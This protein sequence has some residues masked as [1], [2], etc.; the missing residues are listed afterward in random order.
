MKYRIKNIRLL[1][2]E[3]DSCDI[4]QDGIIDVRDDRITYA[5]VANLAP[6]EKDFD[7]VIDGKKNLIMPG[8]KNAHTHSGMTFLRSYAD[9]MALQSWLND[10]VFPAEAKLTAEDIYELTKL[11]ILEYISSGVTAA[12][13]MYLTPESIAEAFE[14]MGMRCVQVSALNNFSQSIELMENMYNELNQP[15]SLN[16]YCMGF[17]AQYTCDDSLLRKVAAL[18]KKY[19]APVFAHISET[20]AEVDSCIEATGMTPVKYLDSLGMFENGGGGYHC[21]YLDDED[22][23]IFKNKGL[24]VVTNPSSNLK[25]ASGIAPVK[26]YLELGIPVSIGTDGPASNNCLDMFREMFL[27]TALA[28]Y[29]NEDAACVDANEVLKM[30]TVNG[31]R[32]MGLNEC[33]VLAEGKKADFIM[34]DMSRPNMQPVNNITKNLV[35]SGSKENVC[36]TVVNGKIL[37]ENREF[38][39]FYNVDE[40]YEKCQ[41]ITERIRG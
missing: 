3:N 12:F 36:M 9:D 32:A 24:H 16:S 13:E 37:Y 26:K 40:I 29:V 6:E 5:G 39:D 7:R 30:A 11:A 34:I 28:K 10:K 18:A 4:T 23:Q 1:T 19:K 17:H 22:M 20:K 15:D 41:K 21:V 2:M 33:D 27:V 38:A 14:D 31:A 35:Y 25:L 8:F